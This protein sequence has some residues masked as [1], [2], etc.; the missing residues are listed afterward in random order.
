MEKEEKR[1]WRRASVC[2]KSDPDLYRLEKYDLQTSDVC[3]LVMLGG[4]TSLF[5][6]QVLPCL[7]LRSI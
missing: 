3:R 2:P 6:Q 5:F 1:G 4:V 7:R